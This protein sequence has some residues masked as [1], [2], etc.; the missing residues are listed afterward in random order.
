MLNVAKLK[1][2]LI[3]TK[4]AITAINTTRIVVDDSQLIKFLKEL[5]DADN[6][7][8]IAVMPSFDITGTENQTKWNNRLMF[9]I[10]AKNA[11]RDL[12]H[13][14]YV[15]LMGA[16]QQAARD[17]VNYMLERKIGEDNSFCGLMNELD[18]GSISINPVW[19]KAQCDGWMIEIDLLTRM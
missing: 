10:L 9:M 19:E 8:L 2:F 15:D 14:E 1:E 7:I 4:L 13:D 12:T 5:K 16:S 11:K 17:F 3:E 18:E 6:F